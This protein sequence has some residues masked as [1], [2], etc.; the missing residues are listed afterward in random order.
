MSLRKLLAITT[1]FVLAVAG[2][3]AA[4]D[5]AGAVGE[6]WTI[7]DTTTLTVGGSGL[8]YGDGVFVG[9]N[10]VSG[11]GNEFL[12][13]SDGSTWINLGTASDICMT[14][15][16]YGDG[17]FVALSQYDRHIHVSDDGGLNWDQIDPTVANFAE[18]TGITYGAG[19]FVAVSFF[20][21][22]KV[23]TSTDAVTWTAI[24]ADAASSTIDQ[25]QWRDIAYGNGIFVG[26]SHYSRSLTSPDGLT[27]TLTSS[28]PVGAAD[29]AF[30]NGTF[31]AVASSG[32]LRVMTSTDGVNWTA[33]SLSGA[34][35]TSAWND[36]TWDPAGSQFVAVGTS[37]VMTS[38]DGTNWT[39]GTV[40]AANGWSAVTAGASMLVAAASSGTNNRI[41]TAGSYSYTP[42]PPPTT[43]TPPS[44]PTTDPV[45]GPAYTG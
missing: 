18:W 33:P 19:R 42:P 13:S 36:V 40:P 44:T 25:T 30:G 39:M 10:C 16:T 12:V 41:M 24:D 28:L 20:P 9:V 8:A 27:W 1:S 26:I 14:S 45:V 15:I 23:L 37:A 34:P 35:A 7:T 4:G 38:P 21:G 2:L 29:I 3:A 5:R 31:V 22:R 6:T 11:A 32:A 43:P 17:K